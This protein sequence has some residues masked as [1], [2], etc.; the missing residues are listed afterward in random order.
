MT[1]PVRLAVV[2][3]G[4]WGQNHVRTFA[5][6]PEADLRYVCDRSDVARARAAKLAPD[7][8]VVEDASVL[9]EDP[10]LEAV[11]IA[12]D[13]ST[14]AALAQQALRAGKDVLVEKPLALDPAD[15]SALA[16]EA[17]E[18]GR[19][20]MVGHLLLYHPAIDRLRELCAEGRL[21]QLLHLRCERLNLGVLRRH[22]NAWFS[23]APHDLS[24]A[25]L[26]FGAQP[27]TIAASGACLLEPERG[28]EDVVHAWLDYGD[29]RVAQV[30]VSWLDALKTRRLVLVGTRA[31]AVFDDMAEQKLVLHHADLSVPADAAPAVRFDRGEVEPIA[32]ASTSPLDA[33][34]GAFLRSVRDRSR[35]LADSASG[36][37]VVRALAA[38]QQ[39]LDA[40]G[41]P[42]SLESIS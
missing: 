6:L 42:V 23:L 26:L 5:K 34:C 15:A 11:V 32:I 12:V 40:H 41:V 18:R 3:A 38:G 9:F 27:K 7:A 2:G 37:A 17:D 36:V 30:S 35:P 10:S 8:Q 1:E 29:G 20:L 24:L 19:V 25:H 28:V 39:S 4:G 22:E 16:R 14:H 31:M 33:E 13:A 21:G